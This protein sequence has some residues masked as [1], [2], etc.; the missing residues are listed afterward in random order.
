MKKVLICID[1]N[2][3]SE[4]V[5]NSGYQLSKALNAEVCLLHVIADIQYY[6]VQY[7]TFMGYDGFDAEIDL[8]INKEMHRVAENFLETVKTHL[9]ANQVITKVVEG[10]T[11]DVILEYAEQW[12]ADTIV[13]GTH[14][15]NILEKIFIGD[16]ASKVLKN[17]KVP[18]YMIPTKK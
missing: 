10:N 18:V 6:G 17:T 1:Y 4:V 9:G 14:S 16:V 12:K 2:P 5:A 13:L 8:N 11:A 15:H 7:P 3:T